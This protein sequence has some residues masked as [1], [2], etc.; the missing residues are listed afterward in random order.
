MSNGITKSALCAE[1]LGSMFLVMSA[2]SPIL[3]FAYVFET[4]MGVAL[5]A[6]AISVAF[7]LCALI[8]IFGP[9]SSA[10]FNPVVTM[11]ML[12]EKKIRPARAALFILFQIAG[13]I[14]GTLASHLMFFEQIG[15]LMSIAQKTREGYMFPSEIFATFI[16]VLAILLLVKA[17][18]G[19]S[20]I[21]I[22]LLV[23]GQIIATSS[24]MFANPQVTI[25][26]MFTDSSAGIRPIDGL[27][28]I[29]MQ[30]IGA[31]LA[32]AVYRFIFAKVKTHH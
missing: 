16:L 10:H 18:S 24:M 26:R 8:E 21:I 30:I 22:G 2:I 7:V 20:S 5:F 6:N 29:A 9:I 17:Q 28:F 19:K 27:I 31:L 14:A 25:A 11:V 4:S 12:L 15:S 3:L 1:F 13:G 32:Y 23:G